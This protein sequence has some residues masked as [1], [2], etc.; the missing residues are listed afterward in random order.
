M[1]IYKYSLIDTFFI[2]IVS[3]FLIICLNNGSIV[4]FLEYIRNNIETNI[5]IYN[6][7]IFGIF[8]SSIVSFIISIIGY[9]IEKNRLIKNIWINSKKLYRDFNLLIFNNIFSDD[10]QETEFVSIIIKSSFNQKVEE[11]N[12]YYL[13]SF[14]TT[15][16]EL[17]FIH[18]KSNLN[19]LVKYVQNDIAQ[20]NIIVDS[21]MSIYVNEQVGKQ[22]AIVDVEKLLHI[23]KKQDESLFIDTIQKHLDDLFK[24]FKPEQVDPL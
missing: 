10:I 3:C 17:D 16:N 8:T 14:V 22:V 20:L 5:N 24:F 12:N 21:F 4:L 23:I 13:L 2:T 18:K 15:N 11:W 7:I 1:K 19:K 6:S 9:N